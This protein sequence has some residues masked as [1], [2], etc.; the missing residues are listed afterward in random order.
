[1]AISNPKIQ[2]NKN[3]LQ[4]TMVVFALAALLLIFINFVIFF[5]FFFFKIKMYSKLFYL[6]KQD[7]NDE[8]L[9]F[10]LKISKRKVRLIVVHQHRILCF[11]LDENIIIEVE[12]FQTSVRCCIYEVIYNKI[13][14]NIS[15]K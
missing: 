9:K 4:Y 15:Y 1:V 12:Y 8:N 11:S 3:Y 5:Y 6:V 14:Y 2:I 13:E 10:V 7:S